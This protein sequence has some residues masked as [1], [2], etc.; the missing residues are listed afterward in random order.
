MNVFRAY[1]VGGNEQQNDIGTIKC[2]LDLGILI[3][4]A[5][6]LA[7]VKAGDFGVMLESFQM[8]ID[9]L[10]PVSIGV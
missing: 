7:I 1:E 10:Q 6:E 8:R 4:A 9:L 2:C 5:Q 3:I